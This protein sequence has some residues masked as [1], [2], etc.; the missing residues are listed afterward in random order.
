MLSR[1]R[2]I[3]IRSTAH[4]RVAWLALAALL[5]IA[6]PLLLAS[7]AGGRPVPAWAQGP[8]PRPSLRE[9]YKMVDTWDGNYQQGAPG[10]LLDPA[11][12]AM[13]KDA[14]YIVDRGNDRVQK[15]D[16]Q[17]N[18]VSA[19]GQHGTGAGD[20]SAPQDV[21]V[22]GDRVFV[23]DRGNGRVVVYGTAG[24]VVA[25]WTP[26]D[27]PAPWGIA[28]GGGK[29][30]VTLPERGEVVVLNGQT[31][32]VA[33][34]WTGLTTP[35]GLTVGADGKVY[36]ADKGAGSIRI[37][38][39]DGSA[40]SLFRIT[41]PEFAPLDVAVD[42]FGDLYVQAAGAI[43]WYPAGSA[44]SRL[45]MYYIG[46]KSVVVN[47]RYGVFGT[48]V[49]DNRLFQGVVNYRYRPTVGSPQ[50]EWPLLSYPPG[51]MNHPHAVTAGDD[52]QI[53]VLD[54]WPR[55][56]AFDTFGATREE[57]NLPIHAV[58]IAVGP[59]GT[60]MAGE[61]RRLFRLVPPYSG[62]SNTLRL[63]QG[64]T[65]YWLTA[66]AAQDGG[67][68]Y[69]MLDSTFGSVREYG[70]TRSVGA[71]VSWSL[72]MTNPWQLYWDIAVPRST[73]APGSG[74]I[75]LPGITPTPP[76]TP[77]PADRVYAV[78]RTAHQVEVYQARE[79][80]ATW[81]VEGIPIRVAVG[82]GASG[83]SGDVFV[84]TLDGVV[85]KYTS[86]GQLVAAWDAG[87]FSAGA[88][89]VVDLSV[90]A[91]GRVY[92]VDRAANTVRVWAPDPAGTPEAPQ[93]RGGACRL[94]GDK[95]AAPASLRIGGQVTVT[96]E[97][98]G[99]CPDSAPR[100]D[101]I[102]AID[103]S[104]S[105]NANNQIT[106]ARRAALQFIDSIDLTQDRVGIVA[107]DHVP[108]LLQPLT[109][110]RAAAKAAVQG[111]GA[112]GG[113]NIAGAIKTSSTELV[114]NGRPGVAR[115]IILL[116]DGRDE[117]PDKVLQ[118]AAA[119][120]AGGARIF[121]IAFGDVDPMVMVLS[122]TT[123]EDYYY[124]P[125]PT[126]LPGIYQEIARRISATYLART[127][128]L[129]DKIPADM[130]F[131]PGSDV[132]RAAFD[133][134]A[135]T[136]TW[137]LTNVPFSGLS[138]RYGLVPQDL[139]RHPTNV[140]AAADFTDGLNRDGRL[141]FP[142]PEVEVIREVPT[143]TRTS[144]PF[145]TPTPRPTFTPTDVPVVPIYLPIVLWQTCK[146][147][148]VH[149][150]VAIVMDTSGSMNEPAAT[151]GPT[152]KLA[153]AIAAAHTFVEGLQLPDDRAA[154][155][156]FNDNATLDQELTGDKALVLAKLDALK[157]QTGTRI[158]LG[159][160]VATSELT[161][162]RAV[163]GN[164]RVIVLLTDGRP[165]GVDNAAVLAAAEQAR[166]AGIV[167][168]AIGLGSDLDPDLLRGVAGDAKRFFSA[169]TAGELAGIYGAIA[170]TLQC[171]NLSWP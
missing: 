57:L 23:T 17:M 72:A 86:A 141:R 155:V 36:V 68:R 124:A 3:H 108:K 27:L 14:I 135:N 11:G 163:M 169:P 116:T 170:Y 113:T 31:G 98:G 97:V 161:G 120:K 6:G 33:A 52:G 62:I 81:P 34:R 1:L 59:T 101:L 80:V 15:F 47:S 48:A 100:S 51:R 55:L 66:L 9:A 112:L 105:M 164:T 87:A 16:L 75:P 137:T 90:D 64:T 104:F 2:L 78:N 171:V 65:D 70:I 106:E 121:T 127:M 167:V 117:D 71:L 126:T 22:D 142:V 37:Y 92:T 21:A 160:Q 138:L 7:L 136:L 58:D 39:A 159:L 94:R 56:Q 110:D 67:W 115:V 147:K 134:A 140:E 148:A 41:Q 4:S 154:L 131:V 83:Q 69:S 45:A 132:P 118:E 54:D 153:A 109:N 40:P 96:L 102:L 95:R 60:L 19:W 146:D 50:R 42:E 29:V 128:T 133:G 158:D 157:T 38:G 25:V 119:A 88:S 43:V 73:P 162:P 35:Y 28:A 129:V 151:G 143:P 12:M 166:G 144:T 74:G 139:G 30:Y 114:G 168:Y 18:F 99:S 84:L 111:I 26:A 152:T 149:A 49:N 150:D 10:S 107:F 122:A 76:T 145:P 53:W 130:R 13:G 63:A 24:D 103:K 89:E 46:L 20:L 8:T 91:A 79:R 156:S 32:A 165:T 93:A 125:D 44:V 77:N 5:F 82:P 61:A 123:P 85:S